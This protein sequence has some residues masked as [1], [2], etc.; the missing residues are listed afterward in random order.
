MNWSVETK[1]ASQDRQSYSNVHLLHDLRRSH[2]KLVGG[3]ERCIIIHRT[4]LYIGPHPSHELHWRMRITANTATPTDYPADII[5][6]Y[7][8]LK[9]NVD[10]SIE[11]KALNSQVMERKV[12][13]QLLLQCVLA[14]VVHASTEPRNGESYQTTFAGTS[15]S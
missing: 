2:I 10:L 5:A 3:A 4:P 14:L 1:D 6:L 13:L 8:V 7:C 9:P 11:Q 15:V 12:P